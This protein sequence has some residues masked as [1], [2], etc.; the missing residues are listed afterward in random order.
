M[1]RVPTFL[2][3]DLGAESGR[4]VLGRL[5]DRSIELEEIHRFSNGGVLVPNQ[6]DS[7]PSL[8]WDV[9]R[10]WGEIQQGVIL[11][12][13]KAHT[14]ISSVGVDTWGVDFGL[15]D[16]NDELIG[17]PYHYRDSRTDGMMEAAFSV[18]PRQEIY[19]QTGIQF[20]Q[21]NSLFQLFSMVRSASPALDVAQTFLSM[22]DLFNFW[23][24]GVKTSEFT[25]ATTTQCY[26]PSQQNWAYPL[27]ER[28]GI[29]ERMFK[30]ITPPGTVLGKVRGIIQNEPGCQDLMVVASAGHDTACAVAAVPAIAPDYIYISSGTWSLMGVEVTEPVISPASLE[31][32]LTNEG[33]V[34]NTYRLLKNI[35][36]L[37]LLQ[38]CRREWALDGK[39]YSYDDLTH[40]ASQAPGWRAWIKP[41]DSRFFHP[42]G[43][44]TESMTARI[45]SFC[46]ETGQPVPETHGQIVRCILESLALEYRRIA[47]QLVSLLGRELPIIHIVGGGSRN[48]LLNQLTANATARTVIA[49]PVEATATGSILVQAI[50]GG[51]L[52]SLDEGRAIVRASQDIRVFDPVVDPQ[53]DRSYAR[54]LSLDAAE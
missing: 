38:E 46:Q 45:R 21:M 49:G 23:L 9:L 4:V 12:A 35:M 10:L 41:S 7:P 14:R 3:V 52:G 1:N 11:A 27:L 26:D 40:L 6:R 28:L 54:Y 51:Y 44:G 29:P 13:R 30:E 2:A 32:N 39:T 25:I 16:G 37:W 53:W 34:G 18:V 20:M 50:A 36:G 47:E 33:G 15:L 5:A 24:S 8:H 48:N 22:P 43:S 42:G 17:T 19:Q 31:I